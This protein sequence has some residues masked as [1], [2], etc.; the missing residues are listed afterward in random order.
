MNFYDSIPRMNKQKQ[1]ASLE[2][3]RERASAMYATLGLPNGERNSVSYDELQR[4]LFDNIEHLAR[5]PFV[6][7]PTSFAPLNPAL[8]GFP[9][10]PQWHWRSCERALKAQ[11]VQGVVACTPLFWQIAMSLNTVCR[12]LGIPFFLNDPQNIP[13]GIAAL[14]QTDMNV[15]IAGKDIA[16][17]FA[18]ALIERNIPQPHWILIHHADAPSWDIPQTIS[19]IVFQ[20][21]HLFPGVPVLEQC[22][23]RAKDREGFHV[24]EDYIL[25]TDGRT[26]ITR[27]NDDPIPLV[28]LELP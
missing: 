7:V 6:M 19:G 1:S 9:R 11:D 26:Y 10:P 4:A 15:V 23:H 18:L 3:V 8:A 2:N 5:N 14:T 27:I 12:A 22:I 25:E 20:E 24:S 17:R 28:Q 16:T 21:V 13:V